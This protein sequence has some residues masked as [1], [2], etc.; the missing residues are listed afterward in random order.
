MHS[1]TNDKSNI[2][3]STPP[4]FDWPLA[5]KAEE[6]LRGQIDSFL[7]AN[8]FARKLAERMR[9]DSGTDLLEWTDHL[10]LSPD[11]E[12]RLLAAG[13]VRE[14][15]TETPHGETVY[16]HP[17]TTLPR[18]LLPQGGTEFTATL[19]LRPEFVVEFM[20]T[21]HLRGEPEG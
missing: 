21:N 7:T 8:S 2:Q 20:A 9:V 12:T 19:A 1:M 15:G 3:G 16:G 11:E 10:V 17:R 14:T 5:N 13:F 18:V 6:F 4:L